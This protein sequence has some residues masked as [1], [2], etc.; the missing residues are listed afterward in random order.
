M[1]LSLILSLTCTVFH[2]HARLLPR[3][4]LASADSSTSKAITRDLDAAAQNSG[5]TCSAKSSFNK[6][7][8]IPRDGSIYGS[9]TTDSPL[10]IASIIQD[11]FGVQD[12][13]IEFLALN[14]PLQAQ[15]IFPVSGSQPV[16][17]E[18]ENPPNNELINSKNLFDGQDANQAMGILLENDFLKNAPVDLSA[19]TENIALENLDVNRPGGSPDSIDSNGLVAIEQNPSTGLV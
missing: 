10:N 18:N 5:V 6:R 1:L 8:V 17:S 3:S 2:I 15:N 7:G 4:Y 9:S 19:P 14:T 11:T 13:A 16:N 12:N